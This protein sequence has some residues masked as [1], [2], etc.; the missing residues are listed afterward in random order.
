MQGGEDPFYTDELIV[1]IIRDI[2]DKYPDCAVT[3][4]L[5]EF[6]KESYQKFFDAGADRYLLR[7]GTVHPAPRYTVCGLSGRHCRDDGQAACD[8]TPAA[9]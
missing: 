3:L 4:S 6:E 1:S 7:H 8:N 9:S 2:K 5:G